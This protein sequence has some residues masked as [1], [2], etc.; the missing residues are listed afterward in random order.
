MYL[1]LFGSYKTL[2]PRQSSSV[3]GN[4]LLKS[5]IRVGN[6]IYISIIHLSTL[7]KSRK[8]CSL[9]SWRRSFLQLKWDGAWIEQCASLQCPSWFI[10][11]DIEPVNGYLTAANRRNIWSENTDHWGN[12]VRKVRQHFCFIKYILIFNLFKL[13]QCLIFGTDFICK[14]GFFIYILLCLNKV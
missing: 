3:T 1:L 5:A 11:M 4:Q 8:S 10:K 2:L 13:L 14:L 12:T 9:I 6:Q 7:K